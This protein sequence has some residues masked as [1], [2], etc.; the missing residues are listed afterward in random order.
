[1]VLITIIVC[2]EW[3]KSLY[4]CKPIKDV[5]VCHIQW[6]ALTRIHRGLMINLSRLYKIFTQ[7]FLIATQAAPI[8]K[9]IL[10]ELD[11][12][13]E[14][15]YWADVGINVREC[16]QMHYNKDSPSAADDATVTLILKLSLNLNPINKI[17]IG[18]RLKSRLLKTHKIR[19][20]VCR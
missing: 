19:M 3:V 15:I 17:V 6:V 11:K 8:T 9:A 7:G 13:L 18:F 5:C 12:Q 10:A 14:S 1:M 2:D 20:H 16:W 4:Y